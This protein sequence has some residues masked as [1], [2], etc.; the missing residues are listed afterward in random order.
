[1]PPLNL[2]KESSMTLIFPAIRRM[3]YQEADEAGMH[4]GGLILDHQGKTV[5]DK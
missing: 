5:V 2:S 4:S 1:M 3:T